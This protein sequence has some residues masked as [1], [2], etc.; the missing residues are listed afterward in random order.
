VDDALFLGVDGGATRCRVRLRD[1]NGRILASGEGPAANIYINRDTAFDAITATVAATLSQAGLAED[2]LSRVSAGFGLAGVSQ[3]ADADFLAA[4][5]THFN[6]VVIV[7]DAVTACLGAHA[8]K[9]G[10]AIIAGTGTAGVACVSGKTR[11]IG[12]HGFILGDDGSAARIGL[13][14]MRAAMRAHDGLCEATPL[15]ASLLQD[16][17][18]DPVL[19]TNWALQAKPG[20]FGA[21]APKVF[22]AARAGDSTA[23]RLIAAAA[24][25]LDDLA[26]AVTRLG[27]ASVALVGGL[28]QSIEPYLAADVA[29]ILR[30]ALFDAV[31][32]AIF[33]AGGTA[34]PTEARPGIGISSD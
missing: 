28:A 11:I 26:R 20:D 13:E 7:N 17:G 34:A 19:L 23:Q 27:A 6:R 15:T 2:R 29:A 25:A 18:S 10:G 32:G 31:D 14:A 16:F 5:F 4:A 3:P 24:S 8:G 30:P 12:G 21:Y 33:L 22:A 1:E 9:D